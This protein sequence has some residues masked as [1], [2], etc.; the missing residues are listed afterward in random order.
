MINQFVSFHSFIHSFN[1]IATQQGPVI[2]DGLSHE[3][4]GGINDRKQ[5]IMTRGKKACNNDRDGP[6]PGNSCFPRFS[7]RCT[8]TL[9]PKYGTHSVSQSIKGKPCFCVRVYLCLQAKAKAANGTPGKKSPE[10]HSGSGLEPG[11]IIA[12]DLSK[13]CFQCL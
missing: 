4:V 13:Q 3:N 10:Q 8:L 7:G 6:S 12:S 11:P 1:I 5:L 9:V 2:I